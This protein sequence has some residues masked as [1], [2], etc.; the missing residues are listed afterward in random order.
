MQSTK[1][2]D[3]SA[4]FHQINARRSEINKAM[5][6]DKAVGRPTDPNKIAELSLLAD[7]EDSLRT[8]TLTSQVAA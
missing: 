5:I 7:R 2:Y 4:I 1:I 6:W 8:S 3:R